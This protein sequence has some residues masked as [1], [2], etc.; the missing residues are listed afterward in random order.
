MRVM[1]DSFEEWYDNQVHY[2]K[3]D[4]TPP[5]KNLNITTM[6][7]LEAANLLGVSQSTIY[8]LIGQTEHIKTIKS[9]IH[10]RIDRKSSEEWYQSQNKYKKVG[11]REVQ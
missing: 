2:K 3:T 4:G 9:G 5:G 8:S 1:V 10:R 6:S 11:E 7:V